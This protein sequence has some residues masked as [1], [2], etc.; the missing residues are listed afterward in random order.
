MQKIKLTTHKNQGAYVKKSIDKRQKI[1]R[2]MTKNQGKN[3]K[4]IDKKS[5][6]G[7]AP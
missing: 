6:Q 2:H 4:S 1:N 3:T 7:H 5:N